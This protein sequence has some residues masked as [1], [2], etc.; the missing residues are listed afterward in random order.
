MTYKAI[1]GPSTH[2]RSVDP[3]TV[4]RPIDGPSVVIV[5]WRVKHLEATQGNLTKSGATEGSTVCQLIDESSWET[6]VS[7]IE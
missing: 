2:R 4:C 6:V 7:N 5:D 3:S 1:D